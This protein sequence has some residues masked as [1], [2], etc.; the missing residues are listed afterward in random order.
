M[1]H[2]PAVKL[3][4]DKAS[5]LKAKLGV[6]FFIFYATVYAIFVGLNTFTPMTME[7]TIGGINLAIVYGF[8]LIA[9]AL[10]LAV[11]YN[12]LCTKLENELNN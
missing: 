9:L 2:G 10:I 11:I 8:S 6:K 7:I 3:G 5:P 4:E 1:G 12:H